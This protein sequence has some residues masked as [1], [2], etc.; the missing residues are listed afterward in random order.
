MPIRFRWLVAGLIV[1]LSVAA[2]LVWLEA[3]AG[4]NQ[5]AQAGL[6]ARFGGGGAIGPVY[7][8]PGPHL[9]VGPG[10]IGRQPVE[11]VTRHILLARYAGQEVAPELTT[12]TVQRERDVSGTRYRVVVMSGPVDVPGAKMYPIGGARV[13][14][15]RSWAGRVYLIDEKVIT[16]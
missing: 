3:D 14:V 1:A 16:Y 13:Y 15:F 5:A 6:H 4:P 9:A 11:G 12:V 8:E 7:I 2:V 10:Q